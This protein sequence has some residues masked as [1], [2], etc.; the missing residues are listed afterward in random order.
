MPCVPQRSSKI[1]LPV[2]CAVG[3]ASD[4]ATCPHGMQD[5]HVSMV[6]VHGHVSS[7]QSHKFS[8]LFIVSPSLTNP[9]LPFRFPSSRSQGLF[10]HRLQRWPAPLPTSS[11]PSSR[12]RSTPTATA[13]TKS[14]AS[15]SRRQRRPTAATTNRDRRQTSHTHGDLAGTT[16]VFGTSSFTSRRSSRSGRTMK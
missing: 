2:I 10:P 15:A 12:R 4:V 14:P 16:A 11:S 6:F 3:Q 9:Q 5:A 13:T 1:T 8:P 7:Y